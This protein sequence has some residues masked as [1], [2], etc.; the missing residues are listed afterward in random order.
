MRLF[1]FQYK[2]LYLQIFFIHHCA[3]Q[4]KKSDPPANKTARISPFYFSYAALL[5][6]PASS[7]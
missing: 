7:Q 3:G 5:N 6:A 4:K 2:I 1:V